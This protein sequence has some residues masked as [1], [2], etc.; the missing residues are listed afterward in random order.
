[1]KKN[2]ILSII[3][4]LFL[5]TTL[6]Q[7]ASLGQIQFNGTFEI[8]QMAYDGTR[9]T[10]Y[11]YHPEKGSSSQLVFSFDVTNSQELKGKR[12]LANA[13]MFILEFTKEGMKISPMR[14]NSDG[15]ETCLIIVSGPVVDY[16]LS[17]QVHQGKKL[18]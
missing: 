2:F 1:M 3:F 4:V 16:V 10:F 7:S 8:G 15:E 18:I 12:L 13:K 11:V 17:Q 9:F 5:F 14:L 6:A